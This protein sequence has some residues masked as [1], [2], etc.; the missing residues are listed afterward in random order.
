MM[1]TNNHERPAMA[2]KLFQDSA[3]AGPPDP[4]VEQKAPRSRP[5]DRNAAAAHL[6]GAPAPLPPTVMASGPR[7]KVKG[8]IYPATELEAGLCLGHF[9][10][11]TEPQFFHSRQPS[12]RLLEAAVYGIATEDEERRI[13]LARRRTALRQAFLKGVSYN[14]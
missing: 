4:A 12:L 6:C 9:C 13:R 5:L 3:G 14:G 7:C 11:D 8:C 10:Q 1:H 2:R